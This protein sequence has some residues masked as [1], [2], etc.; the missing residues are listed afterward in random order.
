MNRRNFLTSLI[1]A[2]SAGLPVAAVAQAAIDGERKFYANGK[3]KPF[4]G[5]TVICHLPQQ[6]AESLAFNALLDIYRAAIDYPF[7][8]NATLLPP[9]SY[10]MT[11]FGGAND[12]GR[13]KGGQWPQ[14]LAAD[15]PLA[16]CNRIVGERLRGLR[17]N[18]SL[19]IRMRVDMEA[20]TP[21]GAALIL[22]LKP[23]DSLENNKLRTLRHRLSEATG[24]TIPDQDTYGFHISSG[25]WIT[26]L[27]TEQAVAFDKARHEWRSAVD[28]AA[29][30]IALGAP[31]YCIFK[32]MFAFERQFYLS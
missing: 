16:D 14:N 15:L 18:T 13:G 2:A 25:Y 3:V 26:P 23:A 27:S 8:S 17:L 29:P 10:H 30:V 19:P 7:L 32:D 4:A 22:P 24:I 5:N 28:K 20:A 9:S 31:E 6:G 21:E 12:Q 11:V 1:A